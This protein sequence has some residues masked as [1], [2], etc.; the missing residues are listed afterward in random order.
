MKQL[1]LTLLIFGLAGCTKLPENYGVYCSDGAL[2]AVHPQKIKF[3]GNLSEAI[4]GL[5]GPSGPELNR[6]DHV[7]VFEK[8][9]DPKRIRLVRLSFQKTGTV[10]NIAWLQPVGVNLWVVS[11]GIDINISPIDGRK[12][13]YRVTPKV[14][15]GEGFYAIHFGGLDRISTIEAAAGN[16]AYDFVIG[17]KGKYLSYAEQTSSND[18]TLR[19]EADRL[20]SKMNRLFNNGDFEEI[21][22]IY[23]PQGR[24]LSGVELNEFIKGQRIWRQAAGNIVSTEIVSSQIADQSGTFELETRYSIKGVQKEKMTIAKIDEKYVITSLE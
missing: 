20:M 18:K 15:L 12:D 14:Q 3:T 11:E 22:E 17:S 1:L 10:Q 24:Q 7:I 8:E 23:R 13:M 5:T 9:M 6:L 2:Q 19:T 21:R 4:T 16:D